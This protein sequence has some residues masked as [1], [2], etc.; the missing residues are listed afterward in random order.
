MKLEKKSFNLNFFHN[1][2]TT[3]S[4]EQANE[5]PVGAYLSEMNLIHCDFERMSCSEKSHL[6]PKAERSSK[7]KHGKKSKVT[8]FSRIFGRRKRGFLQRKERFTGQPCSK[9]RVKCNSSRQ[10]NEENLQD[11][12]NSLN[13]SDEIARE[14]AANW[15]LNRNKRRRM[16]TCEQLEKVTSDGKSTLHD[17]RKTLVVVKRLEIY[18]LI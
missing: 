1:Q 15:H 11:I 12:F 8:R 18:G 13:N 14:A 6:I 5:M 2:T 9:K 3:P 7:S 16:A 17:L 10:E 4:K